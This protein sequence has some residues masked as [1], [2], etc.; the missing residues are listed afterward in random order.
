MSIGV[1][2][3]APG[4]LVSF[5]TGL[6]SP[7]ALPRVFDVG[8]GLF[9]VSAEMGRTSGQSRELSGTFA[10]LCQQVDIT[11]ENLEQEIAAM[12]K[13]VEALESLQSKAKL[14]RVG[15][16]AVGVLNEV[17]QLCLVA[18]LNIPWALDSGSSYEKLGSSASQSRGRAQEK[19]P[20]K[21]CGLVREEK[22]MASP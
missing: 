9:V 13:K 22:G 19:W 7:V 2:I 10:H 6:M 15:K 18:R 1:G 3:L 5:T 8:I 21:V 4:I 17:F 14:L 16:C 20:C 11:R 12:N